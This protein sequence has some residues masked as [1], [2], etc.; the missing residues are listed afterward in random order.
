M[1]LKDHP[2]RE[3]YDQIAEALKRMD[4]PVT[5][6]AGWL[7]ALCIESGA[8]DVGFVQVDSEA[9]SKCRKDVHE[10]FPAARSLVSIVCRLI[11]EN[12]WSQSR[13]L[14]DTEFIRCFEHV[15]HTAHRISARLWEKGV[16]S[17]SPASGFP[18]DMEKWPDKMWP[19]SHKTVA[20]AAG[21]GRIGHHRMVIHPRFGNFIILGTMLLDASISDYN[22]P[23][24]YNPCFECM[25]CV[26]V[27]P[28]GAI[29]KD[30]HFAFST[31]MTHNYRDRLGGFIDWVDNVVSSHS[32]EDYRAKVSDQETVSMWQS[33]AYGTSNR[34]SHCMAVC[35]AGE[36]IIGPYILSKKD[37]LQS[38]VRPLKEKKETIFVM[39]KSDGEAHVMRRFPH[40]EVRLVHSGFRPRSAGN[41]L[42]ALPLMFN[43]NQSEGLNATYH[44]TFTGEESISATVVIREK[45]LVIEEGHTGK[46]DLHVRADSR[47]WIK[48]LTGEKNM[49]LALIGGNLRISGNPLLL[50]RFGRCFPA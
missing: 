47:S 10:V 37:F 36:D 31:C 24:D 5:L 25:L 18:M 17:A 29:A 20:E 35:P 42:D 44:F 6:D 14:A 1:E 38:I 16:R 3:R 4:R 39:P 23:L 8:D 49:L 41:F 9:L 26:S 40:K 2:M 7:R 22:L 30:G 27:C 33:L 34:C 13:S 32:P 21:M 45:K 19:I 50:S 46:P 28:V 12:I 43:R 48:C 15:N 11:P